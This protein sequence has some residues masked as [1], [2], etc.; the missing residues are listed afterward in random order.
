MRDE[1]IN[2]KAG[3]VKPAVYSHNEDRSKQ[4]TRHSNIVSMHH[5]GIAKVGEQNIKP[6]EKLQ[7]LIYR[8]KWMNAR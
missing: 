4:L 5:F 1:L 3:E 8:R 2:G 6:K 7:N